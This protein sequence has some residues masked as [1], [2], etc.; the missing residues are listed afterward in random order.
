MIRYSAHCPK[1][2]NRWETTQPNTSIGCGCGG[3]V[4]FN[5]GTCEHGKQRGQC[6]NNDCE[7]RK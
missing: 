1:C 5:Q 4:D 6:S 2:G 3:K 7:F